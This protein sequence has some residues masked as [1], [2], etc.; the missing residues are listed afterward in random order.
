MHTADRTQRSQAGIFLHPSL[1]WN[2]AYVIGRYTTEYQRRNVNKPSTNPS[3]YN[4]G[5][6][7]RNAG[8]IVAQ[9]L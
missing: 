1:L 5:M 3:I 4:A 9:N 6:P 2:S 7:A 8:A